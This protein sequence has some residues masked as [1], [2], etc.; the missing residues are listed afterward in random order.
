MRCGTENWVKLKAIIQDLAVAL[1][2]SDG[3][4]NKL[5]G[6]LTAVQNHIKYDLRNHLRSHSRCS[7]HCFH[8]LLS[9][10]TDVSQQ[11]HCKMAGPHGSGS[12]SCG[13]HDAHCAVCDGVDVLFESLDALTSEAITRGKLSL[14][15][16][17]D[18][19][20]RITECKQLHTAYLRHEIRGHWES[21]I[22]PDCIANLQPHEVVVVMDFKMKFLMAVFRESMVEFFGKAGIPWHGFMFMSRN[23]D[24]VDIQYAHFITDDRKEDGFCVLS[25]AHERVHT[26]QG[27]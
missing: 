2:L 13:T 15:D 6:D 24:E 1:P 4:M 7:K 16:A 9:D 3:T 18:M 21:S 20:F 5:L 17:A 19:E 12:Q 14:K 11:G 22:R 10:P 26:V 8:H 23:G 27:E 25:S